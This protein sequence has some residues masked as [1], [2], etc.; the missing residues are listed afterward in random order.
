[1][2]QGWLQSRGVSIDYVSVQN[3]PTCWEPG[4]T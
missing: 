4:P 2:H 1:M 3:E